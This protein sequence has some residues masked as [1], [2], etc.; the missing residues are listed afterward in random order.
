F[1]EPR[2]PY[3]LGLLASLPRLDDKGDEPLVPIVGSPP[4][5]VHRP[6]G[7]FFH[8][9]CRF[10]RVPGN[11]DTDDPTLP[12]V[13]GDDHK[14]AC[15]S[16]RRGASSTPGAASPGCPGTARPTTRRCAWWRA[17]TTWRRA[18]TPRSSRA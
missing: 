5:L 18:T 12:L 9:R 8:P 14:A 13:A 6:T 10:A 2:H 1:Y 17:T 3:T 16:A 4:S 7:C 11:C 15:P